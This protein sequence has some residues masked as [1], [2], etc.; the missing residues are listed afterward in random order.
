MQFRQQALSKLQSPEELDLPVRF[1]RPQG[2]LVLCVTVVVMA[3]ACFWAV[4]G[5]VSSTLSAPGILTHAQGSYVLQSP[6]AGQVT[7]VLAKQGQTMA[8]GAPLLKVRTQQGDRLVRTIAAGR[9][10]ALTA[11]IGAVVTTGADVA[12][13]ERSGAADNP[14]MVMLYLPAD[15]GSAVPV[16]APV[17]LTV[18][19]VPAQQYGV[20]RGRV[21][22]VG[23]A[24][25]TREQISGFLGDSQLGEQF[26]QHGRPLAVLVCLDRS[27]TTRSGYRW[28]SAQGPPYKIDSMTL[29][30]GSIHLADQRPIDWLLP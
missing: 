12:S 9:V 13:V 28:S 30:T 8:A 16:G 19:S 7:D 22:A 18:R 29:T 2:W 1:A 10:T 6:V 25:Q 23:G 27:A 4:T 26:S 5:S 24:P 11:T 20:L 3:A 21:T 17:D 14:L 15:N